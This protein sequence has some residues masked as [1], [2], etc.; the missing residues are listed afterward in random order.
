MIAVAGH[1]RP[2][3]D[4]VEVAGCDVCGRVKRIRRV[5]AVNRGSRPGIIVGRQIRGAS[6]SERALRVVKEGIW[7]LLVVGIVG[8]SVMLLSG[9]S[10]C[11]GAIFGFQE[12]WQ[13]SLREYR[14]ALGGS[15]LLFRRSFSPWD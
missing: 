5:C 3:V 7:I 2:G 8:F 11:P 1:G 6:A 12:L 15:S 14:S 9:D 10:I 4:G 13:A